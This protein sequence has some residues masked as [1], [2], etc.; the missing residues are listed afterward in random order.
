MDTQTL[1]DNILTTQLKKVVNWARRS[2]LWP[3]AVRHRLLRDRVDGHRFQ[4]LRPR[5]LRR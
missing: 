5:P 4:P 1:P 3:I 2:S